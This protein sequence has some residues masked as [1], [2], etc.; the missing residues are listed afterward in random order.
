MLSE[1]G[2]TIIHVHVSQLKLET[3]TRVHALHPNRLPRSDGA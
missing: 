2:F 3:V 1:Q